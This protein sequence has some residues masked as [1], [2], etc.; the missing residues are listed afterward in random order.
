MFGEK[1]QNRTVVDSFYVMVKKTNK[2]MGIDM[3]ILFLHIGDMHIRDKRGV[4]SFRI[5]KI[6]DVVN[7]FFIVDKVI[8]VISGDIAHS[9]TSDQYKYAG[10]LVGDIITGIKKQTGYKGKI[11]VICVP[12]NHDIENPMCF[13]DL[14]NI[15]TT[16]KYEMH[17]QEE[18]NKQ[19]GFFNFA[20]Y[21][22]CFIDDNI[23]S[24]RILIYDD[25]KI[26]VNLINSGI[27]SV[28]KKDKGYHFIPVHLVEKLKEPTNAELVVTLMHHAPEWY[29]NEQ[30]N[31]LEEAICAKS[32][33]VFFGHEHYIA[34]KTVTFENNLPSVIQE[35]GCLCVN[36]VWINSCF[37]IGIYDTESCS[38]NHVE[39]CW[40]E[41][42]QQY[43]AQ[44]LH[45]EHLQFKPSIE[46][47]IQI[48]AEFRSAFLTDPKHE[49]SSDFRK[50]YVFP[51][52]QSTERDGHNREFV[53]R[54]SFIEEI[55]SKK[56]IVIV[57]S[58]NSGK[59]ALIKCLF[60]QFHSRD[61]SVLF[62]DVNNIR[63]NNAER[64][65]KN[66]FEEIYG[67]NLSDYE[68]YCQL[69]KA[70][71]V[72]FI[73]DIDRIKPKSFESFISQIGEKFEYFVFSSREVID[74]SLLERMKTQLMAVDSIYK[75]QIMP[76]YADKRRELVKK[77]VEIKS[78]DSAMAEKTAKALSDALTEQ[79]RFLTP[80]PD[81]IIKYVEYYCNN[82]GDINTNDNGVFSKVFEAN[83]TN[84]ISKYTTKN[85][86]VD[87]VFVLLSKV[88]YHIHFNKVY[89]ISELQ[90]QEVINKY[91]EDYGNT[92]RASEFIGIVE[93]AKILIYDVSKQGYRFANRSYLA[94]YVAKEINSQYNSTGNDTALQK[95]L[96]C[97]CFGINPDILLFISYITDNIRI[98]R[99]ILGMTKEYTKGWEEFDFSTNVPRFLKEYR[100][101]TVELPEE[102]AL[103][104]EQQTEI[105]NEKAVE[106]SLQTIDIYDYSEDDSEEFVNQFIRAVQ[107]LI[108]V[109]RCLPSFEHSLPKTEKE[110]FVKA[111]Y[112]L[113]NK[114]FNLWVTEAG[115]EVDEIVEFFKEQSQDY[116][117][118][119]RK[120]DESD[121]VQA[122]QWSAMSLLLD[123]YNFPAYF[124]TKDNT[125]THLSKFPYGEKS[126][127][128]LEYLMMLERKASPTEFIKEAIDSRD[129]DSSI[130]YTTLLK[131]IISHALVFRT[132][133]YNSQAQQLQSHFFPDA[134]TQ[135]KL[136]TLRLQK[137]ISED[138]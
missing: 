122:L 45:E 10:Y 7:S 29:V 118:R 134:K 111:I 40:N 56:K 85:L 50:Y 107:L 72:L 79:R 98:L 4:N 17:I 131:R 59:T 83:L 89:P 95:V 84:S 78:T 37:H 60:F 120:M 81:F 48:Q 43:E 39:Y 109:S 91:N 92:V 115:K 44:E 27:F 124:A 49:I 94:Y 130:L 3:Q 16:R 6:V 62:C 71:K 75:Y 21:N 87:K 102:N 64:I 34:K 38:Y 66:C 113:P 15:R 101:H 129:N 82:I 32:S 100:A 103:Q 58:E 99:L 63:G 108:I 90:I 35:G 125:I 112:S 1:L 135:K 97:A 30:S 88:A 28:S 104:Q 70:K 51:R 127:Y 5:K 47:S 106:E 11:D 93:K 57:G 8:L 110:E 116:Y 114:A 52:I 55:I 117:M 123:L 26:E 14:Q 67:T 77:I 65:I 22:S 137:K 9:G 2:G 121:I 128:R 31:A 36:E 20:N 61:Y 18:L 46:K 69:P 132:D 119:Q 73:D 42:Q 25:F 24:R 33:I 53:E 96:K 80:N 74:I 126:T 136:T 68:R 41:R 12:G 133:F 23:L 138:E 19:S 54:N 105:E 86:L 13:E 76:L